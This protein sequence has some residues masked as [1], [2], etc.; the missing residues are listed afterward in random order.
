MPLVNFALDNDYQEMFEAIDAC[1]SKALQIPCLVLIYTTIDSLGWLA[2]G[3]MEKSAKNRFVHWAATYLMPS[4][5][6]EFSALDLYA[7]RCSILHGLSWES[8][9]SQTRQTKH[10]IYAMGKNTDTAPELSKA[11]FSD[12]T[13]ACLHVEK[14]IS[15]LRTSFSD[16]Y[17]QVKGDP[18]MTARLRRAQGKI[19][20]KI[21]IDLYE[22]T[23]QEIARKKGI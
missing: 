21:P 13:V 7:A 14:F 19:F 3:D 5:S 12:R 17:E 8:N 11:F 18:I 6:S 4:L 15:S 23:M 10:L 22:K 16:F 2:Y 20:G 1:Y 9:L